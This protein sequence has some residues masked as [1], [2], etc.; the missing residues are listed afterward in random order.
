MENLNNRMSFIFE[1]LNRIKDIQIGVKPILE[2]ALEQKKI[3]N[4]HDL[5][6]LG[7]E[8]YNDYWKLTK[9]DVFFEVSLLVRLGSVIEHGLRVYFMHKLNLTNTAEIEL[10]FKDKKEIKLNGIFQRWKSV[11]ENNV[12]ELFINYVGI[13]LEDIKFCNVIKEIVIHRNQFVH[14]LGM[15]DEKYINNINE[16]T[17]VNIMEVGN[18]K[19]FYPQTDYIYLAA[20]ENLEE[21]INNTISF[22]EELTIK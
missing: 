1:E 22:F 11:D 16:L 6:K 20:T 15:I 2:E 5:Y 21:Y 8:S 19:D 18:V 3:P 4:E 10:F 7:L 13:K 17:G 14:K 12:A 9:S